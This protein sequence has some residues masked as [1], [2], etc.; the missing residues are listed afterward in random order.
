MNMVISKLLALSCLLGSLACLSAEEADDLPV[1][2]ESFHVYLLI[3]QS[4]MA[5]RA[6]VEKEHAGT[7]EGCFLLGAQDDWEPASNPMNRYST[8]RKRLDMQRLNPGY[9]FAKAMRKAN[10]GVSIGLVVNAKGGSKIEE[11]EKGTHFYNEALRR[12]REARKTGVLK[13]ILW[14][15]GEGNS[16]EPATYLKKLEALIENLRKDLGQSNLPF[17]AGQGFHHPETKPHTKAINQEIARLPKV[18]PNTGYVSSEGLTT[19]D[20]THFDVPST[21]LLGQ[22]YAEGMMELAR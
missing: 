17:V 2:K 5:G 14:H 20:N 9:G 10:S 1:S 12:V 4:N 18:V 15:Q 21:L 13:G 6:Q 19:F 16:R 11:W 22:R 7:I 3:G 8:I